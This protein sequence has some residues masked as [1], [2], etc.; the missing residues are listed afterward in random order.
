MRHGSLFSGIGGFDLAAS[1]MGWE[2]VFHC[3]KILFAER[4]C[5][6]T[7]LKRRVMQTS[8]NLKEL[9]TEERSMYS[10]AASPAS[11]SAKR[12]SEKEQRMTAI[13]GRRCVESL[14]R[15]SRTGSWVK[16]FTGSLIGT[17]DWYSNRCRLTWKL[18]G[19]GSGRM[20]CQL[21]VSERRTAGTGSGLLPT[22]VANP[23]G[24]TLNRKGENRD[25][26][27]I[28]CGV[29]LEQLAKARLLPTPTVMD[30]Y[31]IQKLRT[32]TIK[33]FERGWKKDMTLTHQMAMGMLP[34]PTTSE[35][36]ITGKDSHLNPR[37][38]AEMMGFPLNWTELPF[39][40]GES[41]V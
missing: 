17:G 1:W 20:F 32:S 18:R 29:N 22:P 2:N 37:Y 25:K 15:F 13:S 38:V 35:S 24:R 21:Q 6:I 28:R 8:G 27:D 12:E 14:E 3:E 7:G 41:K 16:M 4:Y 40:P 9:F 26:R 5:T 31:N 39:L 33:G 30:S 11:L 34:S 19:T 23:G 10:A 36:K